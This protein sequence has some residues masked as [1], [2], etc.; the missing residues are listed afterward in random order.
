M[1]YLFIFKK[2]TLILTQTPNNQNFFTFL[3]NLPGVNTYDVVSLIEWVPHVTSVK[4]NGFSFTMINVLD[5]LPV[6]ILMWANEGSNALLSL[7]L[8]SLGW[9]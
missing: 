9:P 6:I 8:V 2:S 7:R 5:A 4:P 1:N 3:A